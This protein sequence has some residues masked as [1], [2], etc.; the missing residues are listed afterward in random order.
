MLQLRLIIR[1]T[2]TIMVGVSALFAPALTH[3]QAAQSHSG[4]NFI[5]TIKRDI[6][7]PDIRLVTQSKQ[8]TTLPKELEATQPQVVNFV[9]TTCS[10]ICSTQTAT[11]AAFQKKLALQKQTPKFM[12][13][14][15]DPDNDTPEQLAKFALQFGIKSDG[16]WRF[17]TGRFDDMLKP[18]QAFEVYRGT[19]MNHPP[20]IMLRKSATSP[21]VRVEGFP[22]PDE[23]LQIY[24]TL[25]QA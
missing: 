6:K 15:I 16:N 4:V 17:Y 21:W 3:A 2:T 18:Q 9:F 19:K 13:F 10:T 22:S 7:A 5:T 8:T 20:V 12:S 1:A 14:T 23:L 25:P 11:L 24:R